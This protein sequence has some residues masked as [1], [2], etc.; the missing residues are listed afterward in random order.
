MNN[1]VEA[2]LLATDGETRLTNNFK[3][4]E[5]KSR[6]ESQVFISRPL[7]E[8]LQQIRTYIGYPININSGYRTMTHNTSVGGSKNSAHLIG[9]AADISSPNVSASQIAHVACGLFGKTI[10]I[11][12]HTDYNYVHI[13]ILYPGNWYK[14]SLSNKVV[15]F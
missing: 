9:L 12:L 1:V 7:V 15:S 2:Y 10:A 5:F 3:V 14:N 8:V 13:D 6:G 11:G 4:K